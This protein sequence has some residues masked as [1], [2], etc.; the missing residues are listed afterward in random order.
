MQIIFV[1]LRDFWLETKSS[2]ETFFS[3]LIRLTLYLGIFLVPL[4]FIPFSAQYIEYSKVVLF[5]GL[6]VVAGFIWL[7]KIFVS[8]KIV[9]QTKPLD[10]LMVLLAITYLLASLFSVDKINSILGKDLVVTNSWLTFFSLV[11]FY[12]L[13]SRF[14]VKGKQ[15]K[16]VFK[17][18]MFSTALNVFLSFSQ[19]FWPSKFLISSL[20]INSLNLYLVVSFIVAGL[21][22]LIYNSRWS[23][24]LAGV[25]GV[26]F[27]LC[28]F[29]IHH[30]TVL[31]ILALAIFAFIILMSL[32]SQYFSNKQVI[33]LTFILFL[34]VLAL[35][36]PLP[37][38]TKVVTPLQLNLPA[39]FAWKICTST[40]A[41]NLLFGSGPQN[42]IYSFYNYKPLELNATGYWAL[43]FTRSSNYWL[44]LLTTTGVLFL[45]FMV[46]LFLKYFSTLW[47][48]IRQSQINAPQDYNRL[49]INLGLA[50][51][52]L[53]FLLFGFWDNFEFCVIFNLFLFLGLAASFL[54]FNKEEL[55]MTN[56]SLVNLLGAV[57]LIGLVCS[58]YFGV[59]VVAA[60]T[61]SSLAANV[62]F[63]SLAQYEE[64]ENYLRQSLKYNPYREDYNLKLANLL[65]AKEAF[66]I[67]TQQ[68][69]N[70]TE[71]RKEVFANLQIGE[72]RAGLRVEDYFALNQAYQVLSQGNLD[73]WAKQVAINEQ[74]IRFDPNNPE[75]YVDRALLYFKQYQFLKQ[76]GGVDASQE[77]VVVGLMNQIEGDL[78]K[79][80]QLKNDYVLGYYNLGLYWQEFGD[81]DKA[82]LNI[83]KAFS[84]DPSQKIIA[85]NLKKLYL[86]QDKIVE[87]AEVLA[88]YLVTTP[89]DIEV[90]L[91]LAKLY[92]DN[93]DLDNAQKQIDLI[94]TQDPGNQTAQDLLK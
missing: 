35:I 83:M 13:V 52:L 11:I 8:K 59:K 23:K 94:L 5:Y 24:I 50:V 74:L 31:L 45:I 29:L 68:Q 81:Q 82:L 36:I 26:F 88:K 54:R 62:A 28:L 72:S 53:T 17:L 78:N 40:L 71:L 44:E 42:F 21:L 77:K 67:Q 16:M 15:I 84:F 10:I 20:Q 33:G 86:N 90:R 58:L 43:G 46:G 9:W 64:A 69:Y 41:D 6:L 39:N 12:F 57:F 92:K 32:K 2:W 4:F 91:E 66:L 47:K 37:L 27:L 75:L 34:T 79:S 19:S 7:L 30:Q 51:V 80:I 87:A 56:R 73:Y 1:T 3:R 55:V 85:Q 49:I 76:Q 22:L 93:K 70:Q 25:G 18:L 61:Y 60:D 48:Y 89:D 14:I 63:D 38:I 65:L